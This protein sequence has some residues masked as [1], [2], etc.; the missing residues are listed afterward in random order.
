MLFKNRSALLRG[1]TVNIHE[2]D[3]VEKPVVLTQEINTFANKIV[4]DLPGTFNNG[5]TASGRFLI[6]LMAKLSDADLAAGKKPFS[7]SLTGNK[8]VYKLNPAVQSEFQ[9]LG[10]NQIQ[11]LISGNSDS[12]FVVKYTKC[13]PGYHIGVVISQHRLPIE[14]KA[15]A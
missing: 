3:S 13:A 2:G 1:I 7:K 5:T 14:R 10:H 11:N 15:E 4:I 12:S 6:N 9:V 8:G